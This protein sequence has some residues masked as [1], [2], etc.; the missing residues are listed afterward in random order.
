MFPP[1]VLRLPEVELEIV[2]CGNTGDGVVDAV[3][4]AAAL[5]E[6]LVVF[7]A[8]DGVLGDGPALRKRR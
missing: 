4:A 7:E 8:G 5:P 2:A 1:S 6:Y 3:A